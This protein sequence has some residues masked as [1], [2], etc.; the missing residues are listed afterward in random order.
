MLQQHL[1]YKARQWKNLLHWPASDGSLR[2]VR[3]LPLPKGRI[4]GGKDL[5]SGHR[6]LAS[7]PHQNGRGSL[8]LGTACSMC[9]GSLPDDGDTNAGV[10]LRDW[11]IRLREMLRLG[12]ALRRKVHALVCD[13]LRPVR[14][15]KELVSTRTRKRA[16]N[17]EPSTYLGVCMRSN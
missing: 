16:G 3:Q 10:A 11:R 13:R 15:V 14:D 5:V 7:R 17:P 6:I 8:V 9:L 1:L 12:D 2:D 4:C